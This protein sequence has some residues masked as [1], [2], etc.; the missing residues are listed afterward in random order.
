VT[1]TVVHLT[2]SR[3]LG[4]P[5]RQMLELASALPL[6]VRSVFISFGENGLCGAFLGK[7]R[8]AGFEA[9][10][11]RC[12]TPRL[13]ASMRE[14]SAALRR[15]GAD[16]LC[17]HGYKSNI[18]GLP[19]ARRLGIPIVSVSHG[20]TGETFRVR[21]YEAL[22]RRI[23]RF[24]DKVVCVSAAQA[25]KVAW[26]AA[27]ARRSVVIRDA[28]RADRFEHPR[29]EYRD[30]LRGMFASPPRW[31]VGAAG[32]LSPEKGFGVLVDAAA[33]VL[34]TR[35]DAGFVLFGDGALRAAL[36]KRIAHCG[37]ADRF[38][39]AG[40]HSD[41]D[42]FLP[43][44]DLFTQSSYT[45]GLPNVVLEA[46]A[47]GVPVVATDVGG[48]AEIIDDRAT[49]RLV[50]PGD[51]G[52]LA[53]AVART[54]DDPDARRIMGVLG[55]NKIKSRFGFSAQAGRYVALFQECWPH[56]KEPVWLPG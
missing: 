50:P 7:A 46:Y 26:S 12:D 17:C 33:A 20:W 54:L 10:A 9:L 39:L 32:R 22:D 27:A 44:L 51:A 24:M 55:R 28:V 19:V 31:I 30:R 8:D 29:A 16:L 45:E 36:A 34:R 14:L 41:I 1:R 15:V 25:R 56:G 4:G 5:E 52:A 35:T 2:A 18:V 53:D 38:I 13:L 6:E 40:F 43:H 49:G 11:L 23:L 21:L 42:L 48:T 3:F 47:A 37:I